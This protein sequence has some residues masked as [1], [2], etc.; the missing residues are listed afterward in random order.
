MKRAVLAFALLLAGPV[1]P[2]VGA[3]TLPEV[4]ISRFSGEPVPR[5]ES[6]KHEK[7]NGR[8]GP[9][10]N[11]QIAWEYT[12]KGLPVL[13]TKESGEWRYVRDPSGDEV[14]IKK[15]QLDAQQTALTRGALVLKAGRATDSSDVATIPDGKVVALER[16]DGD[17]CQI[18]IDRFRGWAPR[19]QLWGAAAT[20]G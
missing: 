15:N 9:G 16:C 1:L 10:E 19:G 18:S 20:N 6:L 13:I 2:P 5:F 11:Y 7:V 17:L 4:Q 3:Q 8:K 12:R 14:W